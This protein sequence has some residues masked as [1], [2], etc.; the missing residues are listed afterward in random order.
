LIKYIT[1]L[2]IDKTKW[3]ECIQQSLNPLIYGYSWYL[4]QSAPNWD[5]LVLDDYEAVFPLTHGRKYFINY[6]YQPL[7]TQQL[8]LFYKNLI[9]AEELENFI[10][11]IPKKFRFVDIA[12]NE[13][14]HFESENIS[15][16]KRKNYLLDLERSYSKTAKHFTDHTLRNIK[17]AKK[18]LLKIIP[19]NAIEVINLY[20]DQNSKQ[21][22]KVKGDDYIRFSRIV[23]A[24]QKNASINCIGI[25]NEKNTLIASAIFAICNDRIIYLMGVSTNE[26][27]EKRAMYLIFDHVIEMYSEQHFKLDFEGS[28]IEGIA[29]FFKGFGPAKK[30][31]HR[32]RINKLPWYAKWL[33]K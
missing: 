23:D 2:Q 30:T 33:K 1:H 18:N 7:F 32:L 27:K 31:Y 29:N 21:T 22:L 5:A 26:G 24:I 15:I 17:K 19:Q 9:G 12:L 28:D 20:V 13:A 25:A 4:D 16:K 6:L 8:G 3:D 10:K 14:N 11:A